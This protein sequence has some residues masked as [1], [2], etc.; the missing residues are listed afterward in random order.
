MPH[1]DALRRRL[2]AGQR[3]SRSNRPARPVTESAKHCLRCG[4]KQDRMFIVTGPLK[5]SEIADFA[6]YVVVQPK[7]SNHWFWK[8]CHLSWL[9]CPPDYS[10]SDNWFIYEEKGRCYKCDEGKQW[11][12]EKKV[13]RKFGLSALIAMR[14]KA[15]YSENFTFN[16]R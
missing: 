15:H 12:H 2:D 5:Q 7:R 6:D 8:K 4:A 9:V 13:I 3:L 14:I 1:D 10:L 11:G 16:R